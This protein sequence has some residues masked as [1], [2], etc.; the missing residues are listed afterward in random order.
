MTKG[1]PAMILNMW[2][3]SDSIDPKHPKSRKPVKVRVVNGIPVAEVDEDGKSFK[4]TIGQI[5]HY[6]QQI[7]LQGYNLN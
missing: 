5:E 1:N 7:A 2:L 4:L 6:L 3:P